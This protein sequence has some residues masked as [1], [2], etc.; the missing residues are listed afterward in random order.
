MIK[1]KQN[2]ILFYQYSESQLTSQQ[3]PFGGFFLN[4]VGT[5]VNVAVNWIGS[6]IRFFQY[7]DQ[8]R[9]NQT[10]TNTNFSICW[11][12]L[13][14]LTLNQ[15]G[16][17]NVSF[18]AYRI[19]AP[20]AQSSI[21]SWVIG[22][23]NATLS[24][25][26]LLDSGARNFFN[27][28]AITTALASANFSSSIVNGTRVFNGAASAAINRTIQYNSTTTCYFSADA[29]AFINA[30]YNQNISQCFQTANAQINTQLTSCTNVTNSILN[31]F[32]LW[33]NQTDSCFKNCCSALVYPF[34]GYNCSQD[35][36][37]FGVI[38]FFN[39]PYTSTT[40]L[41]TC[42]NTVSILNLKENIL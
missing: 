13:R 17:F 38:P 42:L 22:S 7:V 9:Y 19:A 20:R 4:L 31:G 16:N 8:A 23:A 27:L 2:H 24:A 15:T 6:I 30:T 25:S 26:N 18:F 36:L 1:F 12:N 37:W 41:R 28:T 34:Q 21:L 3:L 39:I 40:C 35:T 10:C 14:N 5:I 11:A 29:S 32:Y 33:A